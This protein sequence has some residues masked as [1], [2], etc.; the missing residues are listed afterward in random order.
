MNIKFPAVVYHCGHTIGVALSLDGLHKVVQAHFE[1]DAL[2]MVDDQWFS[3]LDSGTAT[4][5]DYPET[6]S[7]TLDLDKVII[8]D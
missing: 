6:S 7:F 3:A 8:Y 5:S 2:E 1:D 4:F